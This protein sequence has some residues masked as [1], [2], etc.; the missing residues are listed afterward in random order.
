[1][2]LESNMNAKNQVNMLLIMNVWKVEFGDTY[3]FP[4][5]NDT[6]H[7]IKITKL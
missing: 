6:K 5:D 3:Y 4:Y 7:T 2:F 1:M